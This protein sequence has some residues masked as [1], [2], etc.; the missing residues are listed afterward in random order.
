MN[1]KRK[2]PTIL[3]FKEVTK[4]LE[5]AKTDKKHPEYYQILRDLALTGKR[6]SEVL[7]TFPKVKSNSFQYWLKKQSRKLG[8]SISV[9]DIRHAVK[10]HEVEEKG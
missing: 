2:T 5:F 7:L 4:L 10:T 6:P 3:T 1:I 8:Q 9:H